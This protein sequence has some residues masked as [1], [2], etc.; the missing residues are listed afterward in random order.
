M[1]RK[2]FL[3]PFAAAVGSLLAST[4]ANAA[5]DPNVTDAV[6]RFE[7]ISGVTGLSDLMITHSDASGASAGYTQHDS[8]SSHASHASHASHSSSAY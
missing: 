6:A 7:Q 3:K 1:S 2:S 4:Q 8:H 5:I